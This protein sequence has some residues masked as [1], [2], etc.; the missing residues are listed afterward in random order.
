MC[1]LM[2]NLMAAHSERFSFL[3][4]FPYRFFEGESQDRCITSHTLR[5]W[6]DT[7]EYHKTK[8]ILHVQERLGGF[9]GGGY[10]R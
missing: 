9:I 3:K 4:L 6:F 8:D 5:Y 2:T 7:M 10:F 1:N